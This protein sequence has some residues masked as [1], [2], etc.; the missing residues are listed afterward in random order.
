MEIYLTLTGSNQ[1]VHLSSNNIRGI[2]ECSNS[3][4]LYYNMN[5]VSDFIEVKESEG[6]IRSM[7]G[8]KNGSR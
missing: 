3:T 7:V 2:V 8:D 4:K 1:K 6:V 5:D